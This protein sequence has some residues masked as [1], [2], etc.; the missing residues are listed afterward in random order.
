MNKGQRTAALF[1]IAL[2]VLFALFPYYDHRNAFNFVATNGINHINWGITGMV[3]G[4]VALATGGA[5]VLLG[6]KKDGPN[7]DA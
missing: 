5:F 2:L 3:L 6:G 1:G 7:D 4:I